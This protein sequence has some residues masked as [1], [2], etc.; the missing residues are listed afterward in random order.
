MADLARYVVRLEAETQK[1]KRGLDRANRQLDRFKSQQ[2]RSL[3]AVGAQFTRLAASVAGFV[4]VSA[5]LNKVISVGREF[6]KLTAQLKTATGSAEGA[7]FAFTELEQFARRTPFALEQSIDAF[8][9]LV[10]LGLT[11]SERALESYGNTASALGKDLT[12]FIEAVADASVAEFERLKEFGIKARNE[13]DTIRF[14]FRGVETEV[15]NTAAA[16]EAYLI[17]LGEVEFAGAMQERVDTLDGAL[18]NLG[19]SWD[20]LFRTINDGPIGQ[21]IEDQA[22]Q[23]TEALGRLS[24]EIAV[25]QGTASDEQKLESQLD[26][27]FLRRQR[28]EELLQVSGGSDRYY[29]QVQDELDAVKDKIQGTLEALKY[30]RGELEGQP[31]SIQP[32]LADFG[33]GGGG[34]QEG[35]RQ[36][37]QAIIESLSK[38]EI[39]ILEEQQRAFAEINDQFVAA[40]NRRREEEIADLEDYQRAYAEFQMDL[41]EANAE[42]IRQEKEANER[43][44]EAFVSLFTENMVQAAQGGFDAILDAWIR[45]LQQMVAQAVASDIFD[46]FS[47]TSIGSSIIDFFGGARASGG[48]VSAGKAYMVGERG[49]EMFVPGVSG[50]IVANGAMGGL[51]VNVAVDSRSD[52]ALVRAQVRQGVAEAVALSRQDRVESRRRGRP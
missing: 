20:G 16:I 35:G 22:R 44:R 45:T 6:D 50:G 5:G 38:D 32:T 31:P 15:A 9:K 14:T 46:L 41:V 19:D 52:A 17:Q 10:N 26:D 33:V 48:P 28:F 30:F 24:R 21:A 40:A 43:A 42:R 34:A 39:Q 27:L 2:Q 23:A 51:T 37:V 1:Y 13:G 12:Q 4:S 47:G 18:S 3:S 11:P 7:A 29:Q 49:P 36:S 25:L 8:V